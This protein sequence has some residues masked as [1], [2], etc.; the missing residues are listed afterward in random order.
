MNKLILSI[1]SVLLCA[2]V[3]I[4]QTGNI[5]GTVQTTDGKAAQF[6]NVAIKGTAHG[7]IV[8]SKGQFEIKNIPAGVHTLIASFVGLDT[9]ETSVSVE[10]GQ[11][12]ELPTIVL[13]ENAQQLSEILIKGQKINKFTRE[14]SNTVAK[15]PLKNIE[16]P[17]V[18]NSISHELLKDQV[19]TNLNDALKNATGVM[20]LWESTGR[21]TDG[22]EYYAMRGFSVQPTLTNGVAAI[23]NGGLDPA[24]VET[25]EVVKGPSGALYGS[26]LISY[27]GLINVVTKKPTDNFRGEINYITGSYGLNRLTADINTPLDTAKKALLRI[28]SAYH[29]TNSFQDAGFTKSFFVAPSFAYKASDKLTFHINTELLSKESANAPMVFLN[30]NMPLKYNSMDVFEKNYKNS[31]TTNNLS[32]KNPTYSIQAQAHYK[33]SEQWTSQSILSRSNTQ[34]NGYYSY[35]GDLGDGNNFTRAIS[36]ANGQTNAT[37]IQQNF[38]G[39]FQLGNVRNR[40][41]V[42]LDYMHLQVKDN[43]TGWRP[44]GSV[45]INSG[46]STGNLTESGADEVLKAAGYANSEINQETYSAYAAD[47]V[48][49]TPALSAMVSARFD[50]FEGEKHNSDDDQA[51]ISPKFGIVYQPIKDQLSVFAN[52]MNGFSNVSPQTV[53]DIDGSNPRLKKF[54]PEHANQWEA[55][56]KAN[57]YQQ[58]VWATVSYYNILVKNKVMTDPANLNNATQ[59]AEQESKGIEASIVANPAD[60][61][62]LVAGFSHNEAETTKDNETG[63]YVG[64]RPESAGPE[65]LANF[66]ASYTVPA[67]SLKGFGLG[68]GGNYG[69][70]YATLNRSNIGTFNLPSYTVLNASVSYNADRFGLTL[71]ADNLANKKY[72]SGWSTITPQRL[73]SF[74]LSLAYKF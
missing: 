26:S 63:G 14:S 6:V 41:V 61:L 28:N 29:Y 54:D 65:N 56:V 8:G 74:S 57:L 11:T 12:V 62:S 58:R 30:R 45:N 7:A 68:F 67:G 10:A 32:I 69:S 60:G 66:W 71:K 34:T 42:G 15:L 37:N 3:A 43:S 52:Y 18:Y 36:K 2:S 27:G 16:N 64:M 70:K 38:L 13:S 1:L 17:Q 72:Y 5:K 19:I 39:D 40:V 59:G 31:F 49:I 33:L 47:V 21:G 44:L 4:A 73:R 24:N 46:T 48:N 25:I 55:G 20:R 9:K 51:A 53:S 23:N 50:Y 22:A 35:L